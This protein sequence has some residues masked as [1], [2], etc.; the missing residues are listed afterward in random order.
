MFTYSGTDVDRLDAIAD[1]LLF[2]VGYSVGHNDL[3]ESTAVERLDGVSAEDAVGDDS[4][5]VLSS[6]LI[7]QNAGGLDECSAGVRHIIYENS[8]LARYFSNQGH[9]GDL[10]RTSALFVD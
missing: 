9:S 4:D 3:L 1:L 7:D 8:G 2:F 6:A 10:V 5:S